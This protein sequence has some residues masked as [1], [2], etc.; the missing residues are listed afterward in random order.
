MQGLFIAS[1]VH[2]RTMIKYNQQELYLPY[3]KSGASLYLGQVWIVATL[4]W[5]KFVHLGRVCK[6]G[7]SSVLRYDESV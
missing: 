6:C 5:G 1:R 7:E 4:R 3:T 2:I